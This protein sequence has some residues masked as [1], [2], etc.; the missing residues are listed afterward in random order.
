[1]WVAPNPG[2]VST[3][4]IFGAYYN[5]AEPFYAKQQR[6]FAPDHRDVVAERYGNFRR[7]T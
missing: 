6:H 7:C 5:T 2:V 3:H 1:M 4:Y